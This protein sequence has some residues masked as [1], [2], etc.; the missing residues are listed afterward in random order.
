M[1]LS[2]SLKNESK[3]PVALY[4]VIV[5]KNQTKILTPILDNYEDGQAFQIQTKYKITHI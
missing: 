3:T 2:K 5:L 4:F 1:P